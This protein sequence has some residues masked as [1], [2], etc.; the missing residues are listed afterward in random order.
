M[1]L[2]PKELRDRFLKAGGRWKLVANG[3]N[4]AAPIMVVRSTLGLSGEAASAFRLF[5]VLYIGTKTEAEWLKARMDESNLASQI[6][7][8]V[9]V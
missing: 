2:P 7:E 1:G 4:K 5:P 3:P 6:V 9:E 8:S